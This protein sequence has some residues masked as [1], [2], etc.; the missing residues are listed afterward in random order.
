MLAAHARMSCTR[1]ARAPSVLNAVLRILPSVD[2]HPEA[3]TLLIFERGLSSIR[4]AS[5]SAHSTQ[6]VATALCSA[7]DFS[8]LKVCAGVPGFAGGIVGAPLRDKN[9]LRAGCGFGLGSSLFNI[10]G[11]HFS[12]SSRKKHVDPSMQACDH[13][14]RWRGLCP[15]LLH[16][17][18]SGR[19]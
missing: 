15:R 2:S 1:W 16:R 19:Q 5:M 14:V 9:A 3:G 17:W 6:P 7:S 11:N 12:A 8:S 10:L 13:Q 18:A 4:L